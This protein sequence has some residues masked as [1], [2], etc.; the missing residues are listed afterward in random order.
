VTEPPRDEP[1]VRPEVVQ[2]VFRALI[3]MDPELAPLE[4]SGTR[5]TPAERTQAEELY[6]A[7]LRASR[8][9]RERWL[10]AM[11]VLIGDRKLTEGTG[12]PGRV[13][14]QIRT[15]REHLSRLP[16]LWSCD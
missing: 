9:Q 12:C 1:E 7:S 13:R 14:P 6:A 11:Q 4:E 3:D 10:K 5:V 8:D 2:A 15:A 16:P